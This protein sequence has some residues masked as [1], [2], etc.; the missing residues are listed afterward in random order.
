VNRI[1]QGASK[2]VECNLNH[3]PIFEA[4]AGAKAQA[5]CAKEMNVH[6]SRPAVSLQS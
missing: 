1:T 2:A 4:D 6:V 5:V 3:I